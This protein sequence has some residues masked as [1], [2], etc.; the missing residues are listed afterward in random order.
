MNREELSDYVEEYGITLVKTTEKYGEVP[1]GTKLYFGF[2]KNEGLNSY[3][4]HTKDENK[5]FNYPFDYQWLFSSYK[6]QFELINK[7]IINNKSIMTNAKNFV[8]EKILKVKNPEIY[9]TFKAGLTDKLGN[10]TEEGKDLTNKFLEDSVRDKVIET[11]SE[12]NKEETK[13]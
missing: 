1:K 4:M 3:N 12:I 10:L 8:E 13:K 5:Q 9:E 7:N 2:D 11:A 6:G